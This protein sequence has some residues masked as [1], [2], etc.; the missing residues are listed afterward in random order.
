MHKVITS[1]AVTESAQSSLTV[2]ELASRWRCHRNTIYKMIRDDQLKSFK[3][4]RDHRV[5][6]DEVHRV[7]SHGTGV[8][9]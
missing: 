1:N 7:E 9:I 8:A 6:L 4:R 3:I 5:A 2:D